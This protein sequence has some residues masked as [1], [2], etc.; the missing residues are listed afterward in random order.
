MSAAVF[1][2]CGA[3]TGRPRRHRV[4]SR[5]WAAESLVGERRGAHRGGLEAVAQRLV[6]ELDRRGAVR[7]SVA[8]D[9]P[10]ADDRSLV[11]GASAMLASLDLRAWV[12]PG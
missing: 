7:V 3:R 2:G 4:R 5:R 8:G 1:L 12:Q 6:V 11:R 9:P 10:V